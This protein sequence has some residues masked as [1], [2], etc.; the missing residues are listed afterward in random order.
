MHIYHIMHIHTPTN[1][2]TYTETSNSSRSLREPS[3]SGPM[4]NWIGNTTHTRTQD[5]NS[6][7]SSRGGGGGVTNTRSS[8]PTPSYANSV[9]S[10]SVS[11]N[12]VSSKRSA[13]SNHANPSGEGAWV[14]AVDNKSNRR[15]W[16]NR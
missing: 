13:Q 1:P 12:S 7:G 8:S 16:Y 4:R 11:K 10:N 15:Y 6:V 2:Y 3:P 5:E 14:T 9:G